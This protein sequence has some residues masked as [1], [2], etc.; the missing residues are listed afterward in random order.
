V[1]ESVEATGSLM[2]PLEPADETEHEDDGVGVGAAGAAS[3]RD[4]HEVV[5]GR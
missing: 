3:G 2:A 5:T 1:L 4:R